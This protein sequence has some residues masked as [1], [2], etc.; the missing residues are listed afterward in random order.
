MSLVMK[1]NYELEVLILRV[2]QN[3]AHT[4]SQEQL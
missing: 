3:S 2:G 4:E 1:K